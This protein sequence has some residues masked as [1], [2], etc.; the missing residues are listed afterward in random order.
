MACVGLAG[1]K[2]R[3]VA[4][5]RAVRTPILAEMQGRPAFPNA[6]AEGRRRGWSVRRSCLREHAMVGDGWSRS[7]PWIPQELSTPHL[8]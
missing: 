2:K 4:A 3:R 8:G 5:N 6:I 7:W 1:A